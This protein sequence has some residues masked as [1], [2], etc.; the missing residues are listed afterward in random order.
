MEWYQCSG[1][2]FG[3]FFRKLNMQ[4]SNY[5]PGEISQRNENLC[6]PKFLYAN[7]HSNF[8]CKSRKL[9]SSQVFFQGGN[10]ITNVAHSCCRVHAT[11]WILEG[12]ET[13][14]TSGD[15]SDKA[16]QSPGSYTVLIPSL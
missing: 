12:N 15:Y 8:I 11:G 7:F 5:T 16:N 4:P 1:K 2:E 13:I 6:S 9:K 10:D 3:S 14:D